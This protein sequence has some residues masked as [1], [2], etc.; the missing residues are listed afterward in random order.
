MKTSVNMIRKMGGFEV[1]QRTKDNMFNATTLLKQWN[2]K[3][4]NADLR[5]SKFLN[6]QKTKEFLSVMNEELGRDNQPIP[7]NQVVRKLNAKT[8]KNGN[9]ISGEYWMHPFLFMDFAMWLNPKF[10]YNV[11]KFVY[12]QLIEYR[13]DAGDMYKGLANAVSKFKNVNYS[14][15]A[16]GL[17]WITFDKHEKGI[18]QTATQL[19]LKELTDLQKTLAFALDMDY[20]KSYKALISEMRRLYHIRNNKF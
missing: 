18:R 17:N 10:K 9:K 15:I 6:Q 12:D 13:H 1:T 7:N 2:K 20:I 11:I 8:D 3:Q 5:I 19:Q 4:G 16:K 14:Q